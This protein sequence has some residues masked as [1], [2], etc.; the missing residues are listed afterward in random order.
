MGRDPLTGGTRGAPLFFVGGLEGP[1]HPGLPLAGALSLS[2]A[3]RGLDLPGR[4][5]ERPP[6]DD[7]RAMVAH[8]LPAVLLAQPGGGPYQLAGYAFG[9]ILAYELGRLLRNLNQPVGRVLLL[10]TALPLPGQPPPPADSVLA[11]RELARMRHLA[12]GWQGTCRCGVDHSVP[13][14]TQGTRIA[15]ALGST[16]PAHHEDHILAAVDVYTA[17][18]RAYATYQPQPS[19]LPVTLIRAR[20]WSNPWGL[21][22]RL[23]LHT[24]PAL[25]WEQVRLGD[26]RTHVLATDRLSLFADPH[27][28]DV[29]ATL[30]RYLPAPGGP[31]A[32]GAAGHRSGQPGAVPPAPGAWGFSNP[33]SAPPSVWPSVPPPARPSGP[34]PVPPTT[35]PPAPP[36][37][38]GGRAGGTGGDTLGW[39]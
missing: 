16:D 37:P 36:P 26:L 7:V 2:I 9:G 10:D 14:S 21:P 35:P 19:D 17:A 38:L 6:L 27:L 34:P 28:W 39:H 4:D 24:T 3:I 13:L 25:G 22:S 20:D 32:P 29:V 5:G 18:L 31:P 12:C 8:L 33:P 23:A 30:Q 11:I 15:R 1:P